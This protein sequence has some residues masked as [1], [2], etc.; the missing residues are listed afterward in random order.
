MKGKKLISI[1]MIFTMILSMF[2]AGWAQ[3]SAADKKTE[4]KKKVLMIIAPTDFEDVELFEPKTILEINGAIVTVASTTDSAVGAQGRTIKT[5]LKIKAAK[6]RDYD[7][8]VV[9]GG[10]GV[11]GTLWENPDLRSLLQDADKQKKIIG[12]ICAAPP[13]LAKAGLLRGK[14]ATMFPWDDGIKELTA[15]GAT[16]VNEE[17]VVSDNI[18]T[19]KNPAASKAFGLKLCDV[20]GIRKYQKNVL[21]VIAPKDFEDVELFDP[22]TILEVNGAKV[23]VASTT[24]AVAIGANGARVTPDIKISDAIAGKYDAIAVIGGTG[25]IGSL[26]ED[27]A[28][29]DLLQEANKE[30]KI[31]AAICAAAPTLAKAGLLKDRNATMFPWDDGIKEITKYGA[32]YVNQEIVVSGNILTGRNPEASKAFGLKLCEI[33]KILQA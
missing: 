12:A 31:I 11:I 33:L 17:T 21:M 9:V 23:T 20:L 24:T 27:K 4:A 22:K 2:S 3:T 1:I 18:V 13:A 5:D 25:V 26:W 16:Y 28:L 6:A 7:A 19:G 29:R 30:K 10:T 15:N 8:L 14:N 32:K